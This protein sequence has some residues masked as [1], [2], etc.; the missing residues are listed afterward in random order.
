MQVLQGQVLEQGARLAVSAG[1]A[2]QLLYA[3]RQ[4]GAL[5]GLGPLKHLLQQPHA[6]GPRRMLHTHM[7]HPVSQLTITSHW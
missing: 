2:R 1:L 5:V 4:G 7:E 6:P 3:L